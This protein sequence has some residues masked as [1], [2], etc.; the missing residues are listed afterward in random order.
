M[1]TVNTRLVP[2]RVAMLAEKK[3][4]KMEP[5]GKANSREPS[6]LSLKPNFC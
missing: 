3:L 2:K 6:R 4:L 1:A 5:R